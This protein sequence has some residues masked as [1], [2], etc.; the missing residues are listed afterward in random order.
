MKKGIDRLR[1][2]FRMVKSKDRYKD[3]CKLQG[4]KLII[5]GKRYTMENIGELPME[6]VAYQAAEKQNDTTI[7]FHRELSPFSNFH[8]NPCFMDGIQFASADHYIQYQ[9]ALLFGDSDMANKILKCDMP[10][11]AKK[12]SYNIPSFNKTK[13]VG[14][15]YEICAKGIREKF[16]QTKLL[17]EMLKGTGTKVFAE[18]SKD[19][20]WGT[21]IPL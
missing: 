6:I 8:P 5:Y 10:L 13:W 9:K 7:V 16:L 17:M 12:L 11:E 19:K 14:E 2:I 21:G 4:D 3:K 1:P 15:G 20:L 18:A